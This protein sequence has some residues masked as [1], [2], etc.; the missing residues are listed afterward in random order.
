[1]SRYGIAPPGFRLPDATHIGPVRLQVSDLR[2]SVESYE[3]VIGLR[4][5]PADAVSAT[6]GAHSKDHP[7]LHLQ[8]RD[9]VTG[10]PGGQRRRA[11]GGE[12]GD[13]VPGHEGA[14][15]PEFSCAHRLGVGVWSFGVWSWTLPAGRRCR[16]RA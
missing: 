13:Y 16:C 6:P 12:A 15:G 2:R 8:A 14:A 11:A 9:G 1:M 7:L 3:Q 10:P 5:D 4:A